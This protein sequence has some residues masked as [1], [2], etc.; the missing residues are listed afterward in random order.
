MAEI[1][2]KEVQEV[3]VLDRTISNIITMV[4]KETIN[5]DQA[6]QREY[7]AYL[8]RTWQRK[9][10]ASVLK[11]EKIPI[12]WFRVIEGMDYLLDCIDGQQRSITFK[13]FE[14]D[15]FRTPSKLKIYDEL[16][17]KYYYVGNMKWSEIVT[18]YGPVKASQWF[19]NRHLIC[20]D[21]K[22]M[23]D[24]QAAEKFYKLNDLNSLT[25]QEI[26]QCIK[27]TYCEVIR[28]LAQD[29]SLFDRLIEKDKKGNDELKNSGKYIKFTWTRRTYDEFVAQLTNYLAGKD[30]IKYAGLN[31]T[32]LDSD[33]KNN[34]D[35]DYNEIMT[36]R[37]DMMKKVLEPRLSRKT[38]TRGVTLMLFQVCDYLLDIYPELKVKDAEKFHKRFIKVHTS[39]KNRSSKNDKYKFLKK[40]ELLTYGELIRRGRTGAELRWKLDQWK[41]FL[42]NPESFGIVVRDTKRVIS[43]TVAMDLLQKQDYKCKV[44]T[45]VYDKCEGTITSDTMRKGHTEAW[46]DGN[47][48]TEEN[49]VML[50][51]PCNMDMGDMSYEEY[52]ESKTMKIMEFV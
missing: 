10:I 8:R 28:E 7:I 48:S 13:E 41:R 4:R 1:K 14:D 52:I 44:G 29:H 12:L 38:F 42:R 6:Y 22:N 39:I 9:L 3:L 19:S 23:T 31:K 40:D 45:D 32:V 49:T 17:D 24:E 5:F 27:T 18:K 35:Y 47:L 16:D 36:D 50:C 11:G 15:L 33:Y 51:E 20:V 26:R 43:D 21:C 37:L 46:S 34:S 25:A 2:Q 30:K